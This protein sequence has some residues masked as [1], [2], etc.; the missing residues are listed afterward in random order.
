MTWTIYKGRPTVPGGGPVVKLAFRV[1]DPAS[2]LMGAIGLTTLGV[3]PQLLDA[4]VAMG[5]P[6]SRAGMLSTVELAAMALAA[7]CGF[8]WLCGRWRGPV[9]TG[10]A[11]AM[12]LGH[13][14]AIPAGNAPLCLVTRVMAGCGEGVLATAGTVAVLGS[15][16]P[17]RA[18]ALFIG[19][20]AV[21][22]F[23]VTMLLPATPAPISHP[24]AR[25]FLLLA[26]VGATALPLVRRKGAPAVVA[27]LH[28]P[29]PQAACGIGLI[30]LLN[31]IGSACWTYLDLWGG[32]LFP[33]GA[34][35]ALVPLCLASQIGANLLLAWRGPSHGANAVLG[36]AMLGEAASLWWIGHP[37]SVGSLLVAAML[38]GFCW[39][40][41]L[42][43]ATALFLRMDAGL[44]AV[45]LILPAS[46]VGIAAGPALA[47][48]VPID[49]LD[50]LLAVGGLTLAGI[51]LGWCL[52]ALRQR[53]GWRRSYS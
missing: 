17:V 16:M 12:I 22:Q 30:G 42:P 45:C 44:G 48:L 20:T 10:A 1:A 53:G 52:T 13:L 28:A 6:A 9:L 7:F 14:L 15:A 43:L 19:L 51:G 27:P 31:L 39:Q 26:L 25:I 5:I 29:T 40:A 38:F 34:L 32:Y 11:A 21:P 3:Q 36:V 49:R 37:V 46:L 41:S 8:W 4:A 2:L 47:S 24:E 35:K 50:T 23:L 18:G 33:G